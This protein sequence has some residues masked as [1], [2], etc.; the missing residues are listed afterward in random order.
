[1]VPVDEL[2]VGH[3]ELSAAELLTEHVLV[4]DEADLERPEQPGLDPR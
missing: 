1:V 4:E 3:P 2:L